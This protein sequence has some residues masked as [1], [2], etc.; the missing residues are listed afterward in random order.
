[1]EHTKGMVIE[2]KFQKAVLL[3]PEGQFL[4][5]PRPAGEI[6]CGQEIPYSLPR[7]RRAFI[8]AALMTAAAA[9]FILFMF[10][11][12]F[13]GY[14]PFKEVPA[15][16]YIAM[17]INPS[18]ELAFNDALEV[19]EFQGFNQEGR[20]LLEGLDTG[21]NLF[22][23]LEYLLQRAVELSYL[24]PD[25][26]QNLLM[27]TLVNPH[28][29]SVS[30]EQLE[31]L[32]QQTL[33][34]HR[35]PGL[36]GIYEAGLEKRQN[37]LGQKVSLNRFLLEEALKEK[38]ETARQKIA[39]MPLGKIIEGTEEINLPEHFKPLNTRPDI[40]QPGPSTPPENLPRENPPAGKIPPEVEDEKDN[41]TNLSLPVPDIN[42]DEDYEDIP[43]IDIPLRDEGLSY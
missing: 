37:A 1:M 21:D 5:V 23:S 13:T 7:K 26:A 34:A 15:Y 38:G 32:V 42:S 19:T 16:G 2:I 43:P 35:I 22:T 31:N 12:E 14:M 3:T 4:E 36:V 41:E 40:I 9:V 28:G 24:T 27:L 18:V 10:I 25:H 11:S 30:E 20:I 39:E 17:D 33:S 29:F 6:Q 8:P